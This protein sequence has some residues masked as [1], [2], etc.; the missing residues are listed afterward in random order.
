MYKKI[1]SN[2][3]F[4]PDHIK[5]YPTQVIKGTELEK[6]YYNGDYKPYTKEELIELIIKLKKL[7]P[8]YCRI[9]RI[10]RE[11]PRQ[12]IV[13]GTVNINLRQ[14]VKKI[15]EKRGIKCNCIRCREVGFLKKE[16]D[17]KNIEIKV[18]KY[19][20]N[21]GKEFFI[22]AISD[23]ALLGLIRL[24]FP[25]KPF[26]P[27]LKNKALVRELHVYGKGLRI[28]EKEEGIQHKGIGGKLLEVAE[29]ISKRKI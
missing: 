15:M 7:T 28:G 1:F 20:A 19:N 13:A 11:F 22:E 6:M 26:I 27:I 9:M 24:R 5:I 25:Y 14:E 16:I 8:R 17:L 12:W 3:N 29:N 10:M 2:S 4:K 23:D 21:K 18:T